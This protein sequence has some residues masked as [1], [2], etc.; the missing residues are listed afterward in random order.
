MNLPLSPLFACYC[1]TPGMDDGQQTCFP[2]HDCN[3]GDCTHI[4]DDD[5]IGKE[6]EEDYSNAERPQE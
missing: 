5:D 2:H 1:N 6:F 3:D 4:D